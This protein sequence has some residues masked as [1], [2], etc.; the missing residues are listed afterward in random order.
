MRY[1]CLRYR[2]LTIY[3]FYCFFFTEGDD[4]EVDESLFQDMDE[5]DIADDD[6]LDDDDD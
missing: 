1:Q 5:L 3:D 2:A 6:L 4:V